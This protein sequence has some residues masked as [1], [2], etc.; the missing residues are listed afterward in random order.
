M[1]QNKTFFKIEEQFKGFFFQIHSEEKMIDW[2]F[3]IIVKPLWKRLYSECWALCAK[4]DTGQ[5]KY[6]HVCG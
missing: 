2:G 4:L 3:V 5:K 6:M 1:Y